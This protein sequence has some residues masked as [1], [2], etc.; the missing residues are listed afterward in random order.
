[1]E[2][3]KDV[4]CMN[5]GVGE[6]SYV[7]A[8]ALTIKVMAITKPIVPKA[9]QSL[10][11]ETDHSI[12]LQVVNV[13]DLGCAV[14][15]QPLEFMSTVIESILKKCGEMGREMPE[16]Q[17]FLNDLV[18][19]D[20]NTLFKGLSVVQEK[21]KKVS[22]FAMGAPGSFHGRLFP[23]N[24]MHLVYS[25]YSVHWLS[26]APKITNEAGLPLNKGKIYMSKTSPPAV[27]KAYLSQFQEDFSSL[28]K[29]RSQELAPN[30]RVVLIFNGRQTADPTNKDT[31]YT[32]DLLAE[33]LSYL[34][35]VDEGKL[36]SFNVPYYNPSQE[37][38]KYLV[39]KEGSL[40]IEF[41]DTIELEIGGPNGYWSSPE[42]RIRGH[43]CFTEPLLS[44]QFGERLMDKLYDKATQILVEDYKHG[45][46][47]TK[48]IG[49][50]V[51]LKKK[52]L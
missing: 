8:E 5:N 12:P 32:W 23:R 35:L 20:F 42:S 29:F 6:N 37:E 45:K 2:A 14:G 1:M 27:T 11:T 24:S 47:A 25:C 16:I 31:C 19:N 52:K 4:L 41:I 13:A 40:T 49:I 21:Y 50:A 22:W 28:L 36:D 43:R 7:K 39:D 30:G 51:V 3:V 9:V 15:P 46:E 17:F 38:I 26:E 10:F 18:G 44:H 34:G 48:N 33:A